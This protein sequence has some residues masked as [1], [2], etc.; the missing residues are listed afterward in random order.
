MPRL[1]VN[2]YSFQF[3]KSGHRHC[4]DAVFVARR[5]DSTIAILADGI[6]S[7]IEARVAATLSGEYLLSLVNEGLS[8]GEAM[9]S[10]LRWL[11]RARLHQGPWAA[12]NAVFI[13]STGEVSAYSYESPEPFIMTAHGLESPAFQPQYWDGEVVQEVSTHL[14]PGE[15]LLL[16]S[17]G[18]T[19][20][21]R[22]RGLLRGWG[23]S[24]V[25]SFLAS[26]KLD[27]A[28]AGA[29]I[30]SALAREAAALNDNHPIDDIT[31]LTL[32]LR[33]PRVL[34]VLTGPP[35]QRSDT[36]KVLAAFLAQEGVKVVCGGTTTQL[37]AKHLGATTRVIPGEF[38]AP[39]HYEMDGVALATEGTVTL[40]RVNNIY[41]EP[42]LAAEAGY[43]PARLV[44]LLNEADEV[45]FW[46]G[47]ATN[48]AHTAAL[49]PSGN[50]PRNQ[51]VE[52]LVEK[53]QR[54]GKLAVVTKR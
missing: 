11:R 41:D 3:C 30:P 39:A 22:G 36:D 10:L 35:K 6:G 45:H 7:G 5:P 27:S 46:V 54:A 40:N 21:G 23:A 28:Q 47:Q 9:R 31:V 19:Q 42:E 48:P 12:L 37:L 1:F 24:G 18:V 29:A 50:M 53:L 34:Y 8:S 17:D 26:A 15:G 25:R 13:D 44:E 52:E 49:K 20:A 32:V 2:D 14:R 33:R 51:V 43:G 16:V 4:G 38:G